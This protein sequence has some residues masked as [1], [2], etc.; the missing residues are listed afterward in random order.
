M[1]FVLNDFTIP[2][3]KAYKFSKKNNFYFHFKKN[4]VTIR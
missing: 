2:Q 1:A 3:G 4:Y